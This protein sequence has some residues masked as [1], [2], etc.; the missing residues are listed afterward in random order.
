MLSEPPIE[1]SSTNCSCG[2]K[3]SKIR[4][5]DFYIQILVLSTFETNERVTILKKYKQKLNYLLFATS[6]HH[7]SVMLISYVIQS[8][9]IRTIELTFVSIC[10]E[11]FE[12]E[13]Y[14][15]ESK[16]NNFIIVI[17]EVLTSVCKTW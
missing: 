13:G 17:N 4:L 5:K 11:V 14:I 6:I 9:K 15:S 16:K 7:R 10:H 8:Y 3:S 1:R 12:Q 2:K